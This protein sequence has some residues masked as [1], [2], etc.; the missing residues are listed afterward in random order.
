MIY[1]DNV[2]KYKEYIRQVLKRLRKYGLFVKL[3]KCKFSVT[4]IEFFGYIIETAGV[5]IDLRRVAIIRK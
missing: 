3:S 2:E 1:S 4:E 5:S